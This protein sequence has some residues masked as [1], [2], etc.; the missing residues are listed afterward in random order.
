MGLYRYVN[1]REQLEGLV[2]E[3]VL[4]AVDLT[5]PP[6]APWQ[7]QLRVL[8]ERVWSAAGAHPQM[9]PLLLTSRHRSP[10]STA[11]GEAVLDVLAKAGFTGKDRVIAFRALV[12]YAIGALQL[13]HLGPL[14]GSGTESLAA[15][16]PDQFPN[17]TE[18]ARTAL[19]I[20]AEEEFLGGLTLVLRG[21]S[22]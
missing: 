20:P 2:V 22:P 4:G 8:T 13:E 17:I 10:A 3:L 19:Q 12:S 11:W 9:V 15:L 5:L 18:N 6:R 7:R 21:L 1:D 14:T 16:P